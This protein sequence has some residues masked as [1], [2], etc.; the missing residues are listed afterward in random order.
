[1]FRFIQR[2]TTF[3]HLVKCRFEK[4]SHHL[5]CHRQKSTAAAF[6]DTTALDGSS[7]ETNPHYPRMFTPLHLGNDIGWLPNRVL[8]GSMHT[9]LEG[10]SIPSFL[11]PLLNPE[12]THSTL[13]QMAMYFQERAMGGCGLMVTGGISPNCEGWVGPFAAK[14][15]TPQEMERHK[16][17]TDAVHSIQ[18]P[19]ADGYVNHNGTSSSLSSVPSK[20][21]LQILHTGRYAYHP[22]AVSASATKSPISPF[23]ARA[24]WTSEVQQTVQ[25][26]TR[27]ATLAQQ[28]GY[29][30]VEVMGSEGYLISQ[31][32]CQ[33]TNTRT[34]QYG[35]SFENRMKFP[36][37]IIQSIRNV[38]GP[39]FIVIFRLSL[40]DLVSHG[41]TWE[42]CKLLAQGVEDAGATIINT[43]IGW[44]EARVPT[45]AT[46]V[47]RGAFAFP[48]QQLRSEGIVDIPLVATNRFNSPQTIEEALEEE[49]ADMISMARPFLAD[50][51]I[52]EK[53][54]TGRADEINTCIG[55]NQACLDHA[56]VGKTAS[57][58][59]N[60]RACHELELSKNALGGGVITGQQE[61]H[62]ERLDPDQRLNIGVVGAGPAGCSFAMTAAQLGHHVTLYDK[63]S[64]IGGQFNMAK[65]VPGKEEFYET[66]RYFDVMLNK[67]QQEGFLDLQLGTE[68]TLQDMNSLLSEGDE[69]EAKIDKWILASGVDPRN[70]QIPGMDHP[71]VLSYVDVLRGNAKVGRKVAIIGAGGIGFDMAEFLLYHTKDQRA[72]DVNIDDFLEEWGVDSKHQYRGGLVDTSNNTTEGEVKQH[73]HEPQRQLYLLQRKKGKLG[74]NLGKTTGW[75]HRATLNKSGAVEMIHGVKYDRIDEHGHLHLS[76]NDGKEQRVL[77]VDNI[78][79]CAGQVEKNELQ[80]QAQEE[81]ST[82][83]MLADRVYTIGGAYQAGELDAK[84]AID[85]GMRL[86]LKIND[87]AVVPGQHKFEAPIGPEQKL[88]EWSKKLM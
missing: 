53:S 55:C 67:Y 73:F 83:S 31:F 88:Y 33:T 19:M 45:I 80:L 84:R 58:L 25:D 10:H 37:E 54:R 52:M 68:I 20:I 64:E 41:M 51:Y 63:A 14:L 32:L 34:D 50:P 44:H 87:D 69:G 15:T 17:V 85:M 6:D 38:C 16:V 59:V 74:A 23:K 36:L 78:V 30:G 35:G 81:Q 26:F 47:P 5:R 8:M 48:T 24:L 72:D 77:V 42:E 71:N 75:I 86:A 43:G 57:C 22:F 13:D 29:D 3:R 61:D 65:R 39:S 62:L 82:S 11:M 46:S 40:L 2:P 56:F 1:M 70:P 28:A 76:L 4:N 66:L 9:G 21:C 18:I 12:E 60:P 79:T 27:C 7:D 49:T